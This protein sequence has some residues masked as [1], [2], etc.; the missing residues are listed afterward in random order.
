MKLLSCFF[1]LCAILVGNTSTKIL[2]EDFC[3]LH[4]TT[5][6]DGEVIN[7]TIFYSVAGMYVNAG[8]VSFSNK[9]EEL[10][11]K[12]VYHVIGEGHS[13]SSYDWIY[14]VRDKY[15][16]YID[17]TTLL[18]LKFV[19]N[20]REGSNRKNESVLFN[21]EMQTA[22]TNDKKVKIP[23]CIHD[24]LSAVYYARNINFE[25][26]KP[27]EKIPFKL[28]LDGEIHNVYIRYLGKEEL[29]TKYGKF[30]TI[31]FKPLVIK[32]TI[33]KGGENM[34]V[35]VSDDAN[36]VAVRIES[37]ILIGSVKVDLSGYRKLRYPLT[38]M[39]K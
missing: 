23:Y 8:L 5:T 17:T 27:N 6:Q 32:G 11:G 4:N 35:W 21:H 14:K 37:P 38:S 25:K 10:N 16:S 39:E 30:K 28:F 34:T 9:L 7:Y 19:R 31:K 13:N 12:T 20:V 26:Y 22:T 2:D 24:V 36:H 18:P 15:E 3:G 33:F 29:R 1:M